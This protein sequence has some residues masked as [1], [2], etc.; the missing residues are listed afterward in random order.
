MSGFH[1]YVHVPFCVD[2]CGYCDFYRKPH[3]VE[4]E[5]RY[6]SALISEM[7]RRI[8]AG[9]QI[10]SL[11]FGGGTPSLM[12]E[13][14][15]TAIFEGFRAAGV[16]S[17]DAEIS[18]EAN[19]ASISPHTAAFWRSL[20]FN[21]ISVGVQS[22]N[23]R[24]LRF[25]NRIHTSDTALEAIRMLR[26]AKWRSINA[27]LIY[28]IPGQ[29]IG[30]LIQAV[31]RLA[32]D[33]SH[34]SAYALTIEPGTPFARQAVRPPDGDRVAEQYECIVR[35]AA[36]HGLERYE[37]SNFSR[38]GMECRHNVNTWKYGS[39]IGLGPSAVGF[40]GRRR[41]KNVSDLDAYASLSGPAAE[42]DCM[43][44]EDAMWDRLMLGLR[45][46]AGVEC[47]EPD[48]IRWT[49]AI[50]RAGLSDCFEVSEKSLRLKPSRLMVL[51]EILTRLK[52][53]A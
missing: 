3:H 24:I 15:W 30:D 28:G 6:V 31:R 19:P 41:Y 49:S 33:L 1:V 25:L 22:L 46:R 8:P 2:P 20:G 44:G 26:D 38:P 39:Y 29:D 16:F 48:R 7:K 14:N 52:T 36:A 27:D 32:P 17:P 5:K 11:Y 12:S 51:D 21:R 42:E 43:Q 35:E 50:D 10:D 47:P 45:T 40:D 4:K 37:I 23:D 53:A 18:L 34:L 9:A 13:E